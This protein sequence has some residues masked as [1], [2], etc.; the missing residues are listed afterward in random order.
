MTAPFRYGCAV[1][2]G[3]DIEGMDGE[4]GGIQVE[5]VGIEMVS[6]CQHGVTIV[7]EFRKVDSEQPV[8]VPVEGTPF[9][10][11]T[12]TLGPNIRSTGADMKGCETL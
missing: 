10:A 1:P 5:E 11:L 2:I 9:R 4:V 8:E 12:S 6:R 3:N 7:M